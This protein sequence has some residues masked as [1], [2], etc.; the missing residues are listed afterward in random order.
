MDNFLT[1][2]EI[3]L[4]CEKINQIYQVDEENFYRIVEK[5][6]EADT[7]TENKLLASF[8]ELLQ[9]VNN[10]MAGI[11]QMVNMKP[12]CQLG[13]AFCCYFPIVINEMEAKLMCKAIQGFPEDRKTEL[14]DHFSHY[15]KKYG[16]KLKELTAIDFNA[17]PNFKLSYKKANVPC[18]M[19]NTETNQ[20]MAYEIR[21]IPCRTYVN[22]T[23]PKVCEQN[24][25]PKETISF[26]FLYN[27]YIGA[28]NEFLQFLYEEEDT[29]FI[30]YP[31]DVYTHDYLVNWFKKYSKEEIL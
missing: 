3:Q 25:M 14:R 26:E 12:T 30:E 23:N 17:D 24:L 5:W 22:Y 2:E 27:E 7:T 28:L 9:V 1:Y 19:L 20:C 4:K 10:E 15:Y 13:C 11:E 6:A 8:T 21:P 16:D 29:A 31:N 18:V